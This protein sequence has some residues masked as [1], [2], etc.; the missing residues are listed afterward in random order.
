MSR[1]T[2]FLA[3]LLVLSAC[4]SPEERAER[5]AQEDSA[6]CTRAGYTPDTPQFE[7]CRLQR[8]ADAEQRAQDRLRDATDNVPGV[9][10]SQPSGVSFRL[11]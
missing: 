11:P 6:A 5:Q 1:Y 2:C 9:R 4:S 3:L 10:S 7:D 8:R